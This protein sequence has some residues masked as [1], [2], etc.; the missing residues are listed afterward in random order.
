[1]T[2][3][4]SNRYYIWIKSNTLCDHHVG[5]EKS[6]F[7]HFHVMSV[8]SGRVRECSTTGVVVIRLSSHYFQ[9]KKYVIGKAGL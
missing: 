4:F 1:M 6:N 2:F 8:A 7:L 3:A 5:L 9:S